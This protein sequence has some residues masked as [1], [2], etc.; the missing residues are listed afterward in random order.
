MAATTI[1]RA[2]ITDDSGAGTDGTIINS[3]WVGSALY[4][5]IDAL[6]TA[7]QTI[8]VSS[9]GSTITHQIYNSS[10]TASSAARYSVAVGGSSAADPYVVYGISGV[11]NWSHG[12]DNSDSDN[13]KLSYGI[14]LGTND[15]IT[16]T[17]TLSVV[18]NNAAI[19]TS[20]T[21]G[22]L[23]VAACAGAATGT[24]TSFTGRVPMVFDSTNFKLFAYMGGAWKSVT[25]A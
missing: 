3:A 19:S 14:G 10:N 16:V 18:L 2:T 20:A 24:P 25:L 5:K 21:D 17:S 9:S 13:W 8:E 11:S 15:A 1:T 23:Y 22:F 6:F 12:I 7:G 4:D